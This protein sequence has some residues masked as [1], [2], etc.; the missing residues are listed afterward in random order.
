M[1]CVECVYY[2]TRA[3]STYFIKQRLLCVNEFRLRWLNISLSQTSFWEERNL[4]RKCCNCIWIPVS[5]TNVV[6]NA[7]GWWFWECFLFLR[8]LKSAV[9]SLQWSSCFQGCGIRIGVG[10]GFLRILQ[11]RIG[12]FNPTP[13]ESPFK[14]LYQHA[15]LHK[16]E[17]HGL[18]SD[19]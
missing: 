11:V 14:L 15:L 19:C 6:W 17:I 9:A 4:L 16:Q 12:I 8:A 13:T 3:H 2:H 18:F 7:S 1:F 5:S 10:V